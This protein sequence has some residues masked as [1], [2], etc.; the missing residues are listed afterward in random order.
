[1]IYQLGCISTYFQ[2][3]V[4]H[5]LGRPSVL[6]TVIHV[7]LVNFSSFSL[8]STRVLNMGWNV[9]VFRINPWPALSKAELRWM[10]TSVNVVLGALSTNNPTITNL[11]IPLSWMFQWELLCAQY[12]ISPI[13]QSRSRQ[14]R[15][16]DGPTPTA[17]CTNQIAEA[18]NALGSPLI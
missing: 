8:G 11:I 18:G 1:M 4:Q 14:I 2:A 3:P 7:F 15:R 5:W 17:L 16:C 9:T 13:K 12:F 6:F 10:F